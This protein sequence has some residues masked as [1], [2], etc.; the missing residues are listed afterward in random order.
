M[1]TDDESADKRRWT[2]KPMAMLDEPRIPVGMLET[3]EQWARTSITPL[4]F[5]CSSVFICVEKFF[6]PTRS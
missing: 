2:P 3:P 4:P 1:N 6:L 5:L